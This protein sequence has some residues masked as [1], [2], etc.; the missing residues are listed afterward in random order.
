MK[1]LSHRR[2]SKLSNTQINLRSAT[3]VRLYLFKTF[4][5]VICSN[6]AH[7]LDPSRELAHL[8]VSV[9]M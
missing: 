6:P 8:A 7:M 4:K 3:N 1:I 9:L 5:H 2:L